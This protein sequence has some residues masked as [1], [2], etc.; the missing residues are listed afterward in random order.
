MVFFF[1][2]TRTVLFMENTSALFYPHVFGR[3]KWTDSNGYQIE[4]IVKIQAE[5]QML[6]PL[7][8]KKSW[9]RFAVSLTK[10]HILRWWVTVTAQEGFH[11][12]AS[13]HERTWLENTRYYVLMVLGLVNAKTLLAKKIMFMCTYF[14]SR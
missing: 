9:P 8:C 12:Q 14:E 6:A 2:F 4:N 10:A 5:R 1:S 13:N 11:V 3:D 7:Y